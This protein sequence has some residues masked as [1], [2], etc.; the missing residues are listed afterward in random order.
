MKQRLVA[1]LC[2]SILIS[3]IGVLSAKDKSVPIKQ[4]SLSADFI[5]KSGFDGDYTLASDGRILS[6]LNGKFKL[7][8]PRDS[9][10]IKANMDKIA[11]D[12]NAVYQKY[13]AS[14]ILKRISYDDKYK[15]CQY[16][17]YWKN[18]YLV[19]QPYILLITYNP[20]T[21]SY[22]IH[23][24]LYMKPINIPDKVV[25]LE[26]IKATFNIVLDTN[27]R[28][29]DFE[30]VEKTYA[31]TDT[32]SVQGESF[33]NDSGELFHYFLNLYPNE[34]GNVSSGF[35]LQWK[36]T[37][38]D[39]PN[40]DF[41][42]D[43]Y[44]G[45]L[46][47]EAL[48][49][50]QENLPL[51]KAANYF[52]KIAKL[53]D[54]SRIHVEYGRLSFEDFEAKPDIRDTTEFHRLADNYV[55]CLENMY[56]QLGIV[57]QAD[58]Q[59][60]KLTETEYESIYNQSFRYQMQN[61]YQHF[62]TGISYN[63]TQHTLRISPYIW[64][65]PVIY[66]KEVI[67]PG[68]ILGKY[69]RDEEDYNNGISQPS[70]KYE[71]E[72]VS[73]STI[74]KNNCYYDKAHNL[75]ARLCAIS[76]VAD[77]RSEE[78]VDIKPAW[79]VCSIDEQGRWKYY[80]DYTGISLFI[81]DRDD[82]DYNELWK[83][84]DKLKPNP[85]ETKAIEKAFAPIGFTGKYA[86]DPNTNKVYSF[87]AYLNLPNPSDSVQFFS[88]VYA[89]NACLL[90]FLTLNP[91]EYSWRLHQ[92]AY[93]KYSISSKLC[94][95]TFQIEGSYDMDVSS[96]VSYY[97]E[98]NIYY[99]SYYLTPYLNYDFE[100]NM[101]SCVLTPQTALNMVS[102]DD[103]LFYQYTELSN[104]SG[105]RN[106][107]SDFIKAYV[108]DDN[109]YFDGSIILGLAPYKVKDSEMYKYRLVWEVN[110]DYQGTYYTIDAVTGEILE[111]EVWD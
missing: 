87:S 44:T 100:K 30:S 7:P 102:H 2:I 109:S 39:Y 24:N 5:G 55:V 69:L 105:E 54:K 62:Q 42:V 27:N 84:A 31:L 46:K 18:F 110:P 26:T 13:G 86:V 50:W 71:Y 73:A 12:F 11:D 15:S 66:S 93:E 95:K 49:F 76:I 41:F 77:D 88:N 38:S 48:K 103:S 36:R 43:A 65:K 58:Y 1:V 64:E 45:G 82:S 75:K 80:D 72:Y 25:S 91:N 67:S 34:S 106:Y 28:K 97:S 9:M 17:Q 85:V 78:T 35:S 29:T 10:A 20:E 111:A 57:F 22:S 60:T 108:T 56:R 63:S 51:I 89:I 37:Y 6:Q 8:V 104:L 70:D 98:Q 99:I 53:S 83:D 3:L 96:T 79:V 33:G 59:Y 40:T 74:P 23:N 68:S 101:P 94:Y 21:D 52:V 81:D 107:F 32:A 61:G 47:G 16:I 14:F 90:R 4:T 19:H 92:D